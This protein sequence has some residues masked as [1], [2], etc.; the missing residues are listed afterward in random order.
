MIRTKAIG[1][2]YLAGVVVAAALV[3]LAAMV[4]QS[5][6]SWRAGAH[7]WALAS[8]LLVGLVPAIAAL[9]LARKAWRTVDERSA[10]YSAGGL[11]ILLAALILSNFVP[12]G[13]LR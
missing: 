4:L 7:Q 10:S 12:G 2:R 11:V 1:R 13:T 3:H 5:L 9:F 8:F 6:D